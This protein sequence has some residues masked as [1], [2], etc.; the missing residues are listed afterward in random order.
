MWRRSSNLNGALMAISLLQH[1]KDEK[2][3]VPS[4][5]EIMFESTYATNKEQSSD[6]E[7]EGDILHYE[8]Y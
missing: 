1:L 6:Y 3:A 4:D 7:E 8:S 2:V 5:K